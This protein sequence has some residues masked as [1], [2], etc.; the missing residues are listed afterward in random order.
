MQEF[1]IVPVT[2]ASVSKRSMVC[3]VGIN[4][5]LYKV[6]PNING[7]NYSCKAY[8]AWKD[9]LRR[10]YSKP[11]LELHPTYK[12][13]S[14]CPEWLTFTVFKS[15]YDNHHINGYTLDK[16]IKIKG[17]K[18]YSPT[19]CLFIDQSVNKLMVGCDS[20]RGKYPIGVSLTKEKNRYR[21]RIAIDA[22]HKY[23]GSFVTI[24]EASNAYKEAKN[25]QI[26]VMMDRYPNIAMYLNNHLY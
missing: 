19:T 13:C 5:A 23:I 8:Q 11:D 2:L 3:G 22:K 10:C 16:D 18:I 24:E 1:I 17:N 15:W 20:R 6:K 26:K 7:K 12:G 21:A 4:D 9:M 25:D 14:V